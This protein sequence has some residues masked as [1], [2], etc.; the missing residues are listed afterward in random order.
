MKRL[1]YCQAAGLLFAMVFAQNS[2]AQEVT[3]VD[4]LPMVVITAKSYVNKEVSDAFHEKFKDVVGHEWYSIDKKYMV[5]FISNDQKNKA[6]YHKNGYLYY[7]LA[8]GSEKN[9]PAEI[10]E[11]INREYKGGKIT[12]TIQVNQ[13]NRSVWLVNVDYGKLMVLVREE[14]GEVREVGRFS[15]SK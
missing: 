4:T 7:H 15:K 6:L 11:K 12:T 13:D 9:L 8:Y 10:A 1:I 14:N 3:K 2:F 5:K